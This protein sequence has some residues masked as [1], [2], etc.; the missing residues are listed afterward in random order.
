MYYA[1]SDFLI[2]VGIYGFFNGFLLLDRAKTIAIYFIDNETFKS[3][4]LKSL[5]NIIL[6]LPLHLFSSSS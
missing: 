6:K 1:P 5:L 3:I 4:F 2:I